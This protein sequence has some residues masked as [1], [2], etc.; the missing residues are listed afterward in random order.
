MSYA[1]QLNLSVCIARLLH[2]RIHVNVKPHKNTS[3]LQFN[4]VSAVI[5]H[6]G[7]LWLHVVSYFNTSFMWLSATAAESLYNLPRANEQQEKHC[8]ELMHLC[9]FCFPCQVL[10][11]GL[12]GVRFRNSSEHLQTNY[13]IYAS[14]S[15]PRASG[16]RGRKYV[17]L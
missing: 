9:V 15:R 8:Q 13:A 14:M 17:S 2:E 4:H 1:L 11:L 10:Q 16:N 3:E 7:S 12:T 5:R 6:C